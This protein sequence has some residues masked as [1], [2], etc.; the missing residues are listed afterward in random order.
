M[1]RDDQS[2]AESAAAKAEHLWQRQLFELLPRLQG[3]QWLDLG[4]GLMQEMGAFASGIAAFESVIITL[5]P[6]GNNGPAS[7]L[8]LAKLIANRMRVDVALPVPCATPPALSVPHVAVAAQAMAARLG[9]GNVSVR[10]LASLACGAPLSLSQ[11]LQIPVGSLSLLT[12]TNGMLDGPEWAAV[13]R[14]GL[15]LVSPGGYVA[16]CMLEPPYP[17]GVSQAAAEPGVLVALR[18]LTEEL[19]LSRALPWSPSLLSSL[20]AAREAGRVAYFGRMP[21]V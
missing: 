8:L 19:H 13:L 4:G 11:L 7:A 12:I 18:A 16:V 1:C 2:R 6:T 21:T 20:S 15:S 9:L 3:G 14:E 17:A 10:N 5:P